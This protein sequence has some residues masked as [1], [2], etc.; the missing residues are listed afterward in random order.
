MPKAIPKWVQQ[1]F[2]LL[3]KKYEHQD[4]TYDEIKKELKVD[5]DNTISVF[6]NELKKAEWIDVKLSSEDSRKRVYTLKAP[7]QIYLE[8]KKEKGK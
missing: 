3:W 2:S 7:N 4:I 6:I 5:D 1:R 8:I